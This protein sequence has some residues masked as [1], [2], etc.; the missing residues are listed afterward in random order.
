L[1]E[2]KRGKIKAWI[3]DRIEELKKMLPAIQNSVQLRKESVDRGR[4]GS[5]AGRFGGLKNE[6][7]QFSIFYV[8]SHTV[9]QAR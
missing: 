4:A 1:I 8:A 6:W 5:I 9:P 3:M 7:V 2:K